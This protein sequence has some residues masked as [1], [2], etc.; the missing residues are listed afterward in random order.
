MSDL[1]TTSLSNIPDKEGSTNRGYDT[2]VSEKDT[3]QLLVTLE[4]INQ[5]IMSYLTDIINPTIEDNGVV[6]KVPVLYGT[7]ERWKTVRADGFLRDPNNGKL[8]TPLMMI[9]R[10]EVR[11]SVLSNPTNKYLHT[12]VATGW[13]RRNAYD[14]FAILNGIRPSQQIRQIMIPDYMDLHYEGMMWTE[15]QT[16]MDKMIEQI[17]VENDD[18]WGDRNNFKFRVSIEAFE[19]QNELPADQDR[20]IRTEFTMKVSA[21]LIPERV[22]KNMKIAPTSQDTFTKKKLVVFTEVVNDLKSE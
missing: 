9:R 19:S 3:P 4:K 16:Q 18:F 15:Y 10:T 13:N 11:K 17:N 8:M 20:V 5:I 6:R 14:R 1:K 2:A 21:Y 12:T 22:V 7:E